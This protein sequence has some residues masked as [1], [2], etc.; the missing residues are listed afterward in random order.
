MTN[1]YTWYAF[2]KDKTQDKEKVD[3][4][5]ALEIFHDYLGNL[6]KTYENEYEAFE[7][8]MFGFSKDK[9][10]FVEI[11]IDRKDSFRIKFET[12]VPKAFLFLKWNGLFQKE[13]E[14]NSPEEVEYIIRH[15]FTKTVEEFYSY[16][17]DLP[18]KDVTHSG[19]M[20]A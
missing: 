10:T 14:I 20:A 4:K 2:K 11:S 18:L 9:T 8:T 13:Y 12:K 7:H 5:R 16:F 15:F 19:D 3:E 1:H 17:K 6:K